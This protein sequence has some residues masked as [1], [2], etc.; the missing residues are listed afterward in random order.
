MKSKLKKR[1]L[2]ELRQVKEYYKPPTSH[3][4]HKN[5]KLKFTEKELLSFSY[6]MFVEVMGLNIPSLRQ[7]EGKLDG[8]LHQL[9]NDLEYYVQNYF[10][11]E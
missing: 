11:E 6:G 9:E 10:N 1:S 4:K 2:N 3:S 5:K 7:N 8:Y